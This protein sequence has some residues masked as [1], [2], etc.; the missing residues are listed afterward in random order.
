MI[1]ISIAEKNLEKCFSYLEQ[2]EI[3][4]IR[5]DLTEFN[6]K[7]IEL[8]FSAR[9]KLIATCRPGKY[10]DQERTEKLKAAIKAGATFI[11][12]EF[13]APEAY[14]NE[15]MEYAHSYQCDVII[16]YHNYECTPELDELE[17]IM[18]QCFAQGC[19]L[20]KIATMVNVNRDNSKILSLYKA[21][22]RLVAIGMGELGKISRIVAP[23][24]GAEFTYASLDEG[25]PTAPGQLSYSKLSEFI[26]KIQEI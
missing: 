14:K 10:A 6:L 8:I 17:Q 18:N 7:E 25:Q 11:D 4:E 22:G 16:S 20:A 13:E 23:F 15:M 9:K 3:A 26:I 5:L 1:C 24:L 19:D 2:V 21:P 12:L